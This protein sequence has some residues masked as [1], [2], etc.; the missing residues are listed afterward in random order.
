MTGRS[1]EDKRPVVIDNGSGII[2]AG[3]AGDSHPR[4]IFST[5]VDRHS[6]VPIRTKYTGSFLNAAD[7]ISDAREL[8][9]IYYP[10]EY[11]IV[12]N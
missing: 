11:G 9:H 7:K 12:T 3:L 10:I 5:T 1:M 6:H 8:A 2:K 4:A